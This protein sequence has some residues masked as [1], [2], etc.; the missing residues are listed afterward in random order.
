MRRCSRFFMS[1]EGRA[2]DIF[3]CYMGALEIIDVPS[4]D[5]AVFQALSGMGKLGHG[6][7]IVGYFRPFGAVF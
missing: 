3:R 6:N 7:R 5:L 2:L 1:G 4:Y